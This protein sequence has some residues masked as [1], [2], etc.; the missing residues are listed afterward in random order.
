MGIEAFTRSLTY[1]LHVV[2]VRDSQQDR[3]AGFV[4]DAVCQISSGSEPF[5]LCSVMNKN[6]SKSCIEMEKVFNVSILPDDVDPFILAN[7]GFQTSKEVS[8]WDNVEYELKD[9]LPIIP[10]AVS[11]TQM[12]VHDF[13]EMGSHTAFFCIPSNADYLNKEKT[14]VRYSDYFSKLKDP[15]FAA[16]KA[17]I[18]KQAGKETS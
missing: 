9:G 17:F 6:Y 14:P 5:I 1:G 18:A 12:K 8:K 16:F 13:R 15:A 7:F 3:F 4:V 11:W 10:E 2:S